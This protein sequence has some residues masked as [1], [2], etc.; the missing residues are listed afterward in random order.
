VSFIGDDGHA[1]L[2]EQIPAETDEQAVELAQGR[3]DNLDM[4][5]IAD[6]WLDSERVAIIARQKRV[7]AAQYAAA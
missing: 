2:T 5:A 7:R 6:V 3:L 1:R 4:L